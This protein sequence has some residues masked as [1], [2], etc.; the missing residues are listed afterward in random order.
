[1]SRMSGGHVLYAVMLLGILAWLLFSARK[2]RLPLW[3]AVAVTACGPALVG[4]DFACGRFFIWLAP[5]LAAPQA[6]AILYGLLPAVLALPLVL[7]W[8]GKRRSAPWRAAA[9]VGDRKPVRWK[10]FLYVA[11]PVAAVFF[12]RAGFLLAGKASVA[13][14]MGEGSQYQALAIPFAIRTFGDLG[15]WIWTCSGQLLY[16]VTFILLVEVCWLVATEGVIFRLTDSLR[17]R[18]VV[19]SLTILFLL[20]GHRILALSDRTILLG[21]TGFMAVAA[22]LASISRGGRIMAR[23]LIVL[24]TA[25]ITLSHIVQ[26]QRMSLGDM[27][28][29]MKFLG[30]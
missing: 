27:M 29:A 18:A 2:K 6:F 28:K 17:D 25:L 22:V 30:Y 3:P 10:S 15:S 21:M 7:L 26:V 14:G 9:A 13:K 1:M 8:L 11:L 12:L 16:L 23:V 24:P 4:I 20:N 5:H 19:S